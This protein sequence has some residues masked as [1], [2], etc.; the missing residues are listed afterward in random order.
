[1]Y[2]K[3]DG[4]IDIV[5]IMSHAGV[6]EGKMVNCMIWAFGDDWDVMPIACSYDKWNDR[7]PDRFQLNDEDYLPSSLI[8]IAREYLGD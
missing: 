6:P 4:T 2:F 7:H 5:S 3:S 1:M 8:R